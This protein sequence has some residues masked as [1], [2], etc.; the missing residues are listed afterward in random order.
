MRVLVIGASGTIG[1]AVADAFAEAGHEV[2]RA[3]RGGEH[4]VDISSPDS[5]REL[6]SRTGKLDAIVNCAGG[7]VF[8]AL[9]DMDAADLQQAYDLKLTPFFHVV[10]MGL[11]HLND[12]GQ[13]IL[14]SGIFAT[15]P[16]P[17]VSLISMVNGALESFTRAAALD[18]PRGIRINAVS[19]PFIKETAE[20][21]GMPGGYPARD[22]ARAYIELAQG[23]QT[24]VT[25]TPGG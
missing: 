11:E 16:M 13:F 2:L 9:P 7:G 3:S 15:Q 25:V 24:G 12:G 21:M 4:K 1:S 20:K 17:G 5:L 14:T 19:A 6:F 22:N 8:K 18:M 23:T 10:R